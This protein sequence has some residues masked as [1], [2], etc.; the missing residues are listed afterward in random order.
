MKIL[1]LLTA[2]V[3]LP[4]GVAT[5]AWADSIPIEPASTEAEQIQPIPTQTDGDAGTSTQADSLNRSAEQ[6]NRNLEGRESPN[7]PLRDLLNLPDG[8][9]IRGSSRGGLG[10]GTEY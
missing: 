6:I 7:P 4:F 1:F 9:I 3:L 5:A 8:M 10:I 2:A